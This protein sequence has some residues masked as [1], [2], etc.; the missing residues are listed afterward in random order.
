MGFDGTNICREK[1]CKCANSDIGGLGSLY[2]IIDSIFC[3]SE[4][5]GVMHIDGRRRGVA[6]LSMRRMRGSA[7]RFQP[8]GR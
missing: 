5:V 1:Q 7:Q 6:K 8:G 3:R 4:I 2:G